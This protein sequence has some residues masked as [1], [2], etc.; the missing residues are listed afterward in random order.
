M[1]LG[2]I[3]IYGVI[4]YTV[5]QRKREIGIRGSHGSA[6]PRFAVAI[7]ALWFTLAAAGAVIGLAA[8]AG[9]TCD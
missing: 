2:L 8:A 9:L 1:V 4:S 6:A 7:C 5:L 3:G